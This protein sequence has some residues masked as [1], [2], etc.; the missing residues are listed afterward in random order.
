MTNLRQDLLNPS[1][2][3]VLTT[4]H[5]D[6]TYLSGRGHYLEDDKGIT[7]LDFISQYGAIPFGYN[8]D[9]IW[10]KLNEIRERALPSLVQPSLPA[11]ALKLA[12]MLSDLTP[13]D[14]CYSTFCQSG[15]EAVEAAIKLARSASGKQIIV[16]ASNSFH[17]K[18]LGALSATGKD[19][20][21]EP[22]FAPAPGFVRVPFN[23][24]LVLEDLFARE[25]QNIA[26]FIV[27][28]VQGEGGI[29]VAAP[30]Y[31]T[32]VRH[33]CDEYNV[34]FILDEIQTGL[35]RTGKLFACEHDGV[36]PDILLSAKALGGGLLPLGVTISTPAVWNEEYGMLH[37]S[38]FAN[39]NLTCAVGIA[40]LEKLLSNDG[41]LIREAE[42]KGK[43]LLEKANDLARQYPGVIK[44]V[45]G[46]G[47]MV[48]IEFTDLK[49]IGSYDISFIAD[50]G[51]FTALLAGY[52]LNVHHIRLAP[53]LNDSM[54]L[55]LEPSLTIT[56]AEIDR[57]IQALSR[58]CEIMYNQDYAQFYRYL[59]GDCSLPVAT[60]DYRSI[61]RR[62]KAS[63]MAE[64][65]EARNKFAFIIH[66][67]APEDV[68]TNNPS[69]IAFSRKEL[70][71]FMK[72]QAQTS[73]PGT[74]CHM[75][76]FKGAN[77]NI[78][79]GWLVGVPLGAR[80]IMSL[81]REH[82]VAIIQSAVDK[83]R[84]LGA[85]IVGLGALTSVVTRGGRDVQGRGVGITS[86]NSFTTLMAM[87]ALFEGAEK[88]KIDTKNERGA[89]VGAVGSIGRACAMLFS[90]RAARITLL[91]NPGRVFS[92]NSR[93]DALANEM[94]QLAWKRMQGGELGGLSRWLDEARQGL[95][96]STQPAADS[97]LQDLLLGRNLTFEWL[98]RV[99]SL[100]GKERPIAYSLNLEETLPQCRLIVAASNSPE[101]LIH[102]HHLQ[103][104]TVVCDVA[105][106]ADVSPEVYQ[107][108]DDVLVLEGGLVRYPDD[109]CFGPNLGYRDGV[110]LAC[111]SETILLALEGDYNDHSI[112]SKLPL[113]AMEYFRHLARKHG[114]GLA[115]L[116]MGGREIT[117]EEIEAIY[118]NYLLKLDSSCMISEK[119]AKMK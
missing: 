56:Y 72:W 40:V 68:S 22:F 50:Q 94:L 110:N 54:T 55:R 4:F 66:Y 41:E 118:Q 34:V 102:S 26:A 14:L 92:S 19:S 74:T 85:G 15:T 20:Y 16:S 112:G 86:G 89:V 98:E 104:G 83:A 60:R 51:G 29:I 44:E 9:F 103:P 116:R 70:Y 67:P 90:E 106:P 97:L 11:E 49:D 42:A 17:G 13:G 47:L 96:T 31:L 6:K 84:E 35:G 113:E 119:V 27:E 32:A 2:K 5:L 46:L 91:G 10:D 80:E 37:S 23:D 28:P 39:N 114:F 7:Y 71:S 111:L 63:E 52:L 38:T 30:G 81:P 100:L 64:G 53:F 3:K 62:V 58:V 105:R 75:P 107:E 36:A 18:T 61:T 59:I 99:S 45:R 73:E 115:G 79:Q 43:Y 76:A 101:Y 33:L 88:M 77:G 87:E 69:F 8:P 78:A 108:R 21:Q 25:H 82:T 24:V 12:N 95:E 65:E 57:V 48:G 109:V 117:E 93:L 1:L